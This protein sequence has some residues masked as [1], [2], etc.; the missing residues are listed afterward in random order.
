MGKCDIIWCLS[1]F[2]YYYLVEY[3]TVGIEQSW[4]SCIKHRSRSNNYSMSLK[5]RGT[6]RT[7]QLIIVRTYAFFWILERKRHHV[8]QSE[9]I[10]CNWHQPLFITS[11]LFYFRSSWCQSIKNI[12]HHFW[13]VIVLIRTNAREFIF[14]LTSILT[15]Y[16]LCLIYY[17]IVLRLIFPF[18]L[19]LS[20]WHHFLTSFISSNPSRISVYTIRYWYYYFTFYE[21]KDLTKSIHIYIKTRRIT[22]TFENQQ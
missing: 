2:R 3:N 14:L 4:V 5:H 12:W 13:E 1:S 7:I 8:R 11:G 16:F 18:F 15:L 9:I 6:N 22:Q 10:I 21:S 20:T 17:E 19:C